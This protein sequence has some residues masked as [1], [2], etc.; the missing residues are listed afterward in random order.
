M[1]VQI[2]VCSASLLTRIPCPP[3]FSTDIESYK[4]FMETFGESVSNELF[5]HAF[6]SIQILYHNGVNLNPIFK[7]E[8]NVNC[9]LDIEPLKKESL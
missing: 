5:S 3:K 6:E 8:L 4:W 7:F 2:K 1:R 9:E